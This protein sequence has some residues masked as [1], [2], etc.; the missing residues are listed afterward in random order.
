LPEHISQR[1]GCSSIPAP[2]SAISP[3]QAVG[4]LRNLRDNLGADGGLLIGM[5]LVKQSSVL[6]AAYNDAL[7]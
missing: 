1:A 4:L 3:P 2:R 5:D 7:A 6:D